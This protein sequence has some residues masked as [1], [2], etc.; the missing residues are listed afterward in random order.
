MSAK[1]T[2]SAKFILPEPASAPAASNRGIAGIG[3]PICSSST[4]KKS[5][6]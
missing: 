3:K 5:R 1:L 2:A 6:A 4:H